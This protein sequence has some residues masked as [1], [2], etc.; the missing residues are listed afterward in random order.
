MFTWVLLHNLRLGRRP[1]CACFGTLAAA[2]LGWGHVARNAG[3]VAL[4]VLALISR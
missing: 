4:G 1:A 3:F 2:P